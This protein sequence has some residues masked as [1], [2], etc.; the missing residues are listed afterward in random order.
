MKTKKIILK[1]G[2]HITPAMDRVLE[3]L[4]NVVNRT[5]W[6]ESRL[7]RSMEG[8][9]LVQVLELGDGWLKVR[10]RDRAEQMM[11]MERVTFWQGR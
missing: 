4:M 2:T 7:A 8:R 3:R 1:D 10:L 5:L 6:V 9:G 11:W